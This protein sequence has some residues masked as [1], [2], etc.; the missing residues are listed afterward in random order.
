MGKKKVF[1]SVTASAVIASTLV[2]AQQV[3]AASHT[4]QQGDSLWSISQRYQT[5]VSQLKTWNNLSSDLI[6]PNQVLIVSKDSTNKQTSNNS[7]SSNQPAKNSTY[8]VV[9]GDSLSA[10]AARHNISL[11]NLMKWN[12]LDTTLI[13]PGDKL[14]VSKPSNNNASSN[15]N[16]NDTS[17]NSS[18]NNNSSAKYYTVKSGDNLSKIAANHGISLSDLKKWNHLNSDL[19]YPGDKLVVSHSVSSNKNNNSNNGSSGTTSSSNNSTTNQTTYTVKSGDNLSKIAASYGISLNDLK[20]WNNITSHLIYPGDVLIVNNNTSNNTGSQNNETNETNNSHINVN[21]LID[22]AQSVMG[23]KYLFGGNSPST[24]FDCSGFIYWAFNQ[25]G[26]KIG[27]YSSEGY[28]NRSFII[29]NP[30]VGDLVFFENTYKS[31]ISHMGIY[32]G[33]NNFI[34]AGSNGV[35]ISSLNNSYWKKHFH[36]FKKFY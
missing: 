30:S 35:T 31:G 15:S 11:T 17:A 34:H 26:E 10:I 2:N 14:I 22:V 12:K 20:K 5:S 33:N 25:A 18:I 23:T 24:G 4:V 9:K 29:N 6:R 1:M 19:I 21:K 36:S 32:L 3:D 13:F 16:T 8:T 27:R 28:Y 7:A